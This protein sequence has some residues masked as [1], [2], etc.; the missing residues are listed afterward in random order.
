[1]L[2]ELE[3]NRPY[4]GLNLLEKFV[5]NKAIYMQFSLNL[6]PQ[7]LRTLLSH[8][9]GVYGHSHFTETLFLNGNQL[10]RSHISVE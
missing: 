3:L 10:D 2:P 8:V 4:S 9:R 7:P 5:Q 6:P 1:M